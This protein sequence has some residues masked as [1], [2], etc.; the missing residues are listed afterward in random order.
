MANLAQIVNVLHASVMTQGAA[1]W[2]T[3]TFYAF[4]LH[5]PHIGAEALPTHVE[6]GD[7]LPDGSSAISATAS[8]RNGRIAMT[9]TNRHYDQSGDVK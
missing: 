7:S 2:V 4:Q 1:M 8:R 3:P 9:I 5:K 6:H